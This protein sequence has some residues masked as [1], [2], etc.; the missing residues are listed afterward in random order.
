MRE[1]CAKLETEFD[2][3]EAECV[4]LRAEVEQKR[5]LLAIA[6]RSAGDQAS[7][8]ERAEAKVKRL[9]SLCDNL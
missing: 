3:A 6:I 4:A 9:K 5:N 2:A 7:R 1:E 8:A